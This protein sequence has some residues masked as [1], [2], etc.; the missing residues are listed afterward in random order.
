[1]MLALRKYI[2]MLIAYIDSKFEY[3]ISCCDLSV[4]RRLFCVVLMSVS[5][6]S[7]LCMFRLHWVPVSLVA[8][9]WERAAPSI[10]RIFSLYMYHVYLLFCLFPILVSRTGFWF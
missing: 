9:F 3:F 7:I 4:P 5:A 1:M 2:I 6:L 10:D 8:T